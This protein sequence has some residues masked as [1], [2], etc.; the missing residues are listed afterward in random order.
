MKLTEEAWKEQTDKLFRYLMDYQA[1]MTQAEKH[2][3]EQHHHVTIASLTLQKIDKI[4]LLLLQFLPNNITQE[5]ESKTDQLNF[6]DWI[7]G[8]T[9]LDVD[10]RQ[11]EEYIYFAFRWGRKPESKDFWRAIN[12]R[13]TRMHLCVLR[14]IELQTT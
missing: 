6:T 1:A 2:P 7:D 14:L 3:N 11:C 5:Q 8:H 13:L 9:L 10:L 12:T 4:V